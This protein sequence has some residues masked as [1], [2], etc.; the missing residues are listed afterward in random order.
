MSIKN[1]SGKVKSFAVLPRAISGKKSAF[2][3][4][5]YPS[6]NTV[7]GFKRLVRLRRNGRQD[8]RVYSHEHGI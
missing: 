8:G 5:K 7:G 6:G 1:F 4:I 2:N 3:F